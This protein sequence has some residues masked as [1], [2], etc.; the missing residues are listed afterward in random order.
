MLRRCD[1][2]DREKLRKPREN[3]ND[4]SAPG[5][6]YEHAVPDVRF[7]ARESKAHKASIRTNREK[8]DHEPRKRSAETIAGHPR[9]AVDGQPTMSEEQGTMFP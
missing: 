9:S 3:P 1:V 7:N 5:G 6:Q 8:T 4:T 2:S